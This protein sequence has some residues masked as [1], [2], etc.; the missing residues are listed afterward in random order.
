MGSVELS[1]SVA[2]LRLGQFCVDSVER[3]QQPHNEVS[4]NFPKREQDK[5]I[6]K[7]KEKRKKNDALPK[8]DKDQG[9]ENAQKVS[10]V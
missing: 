10:F 2:D 4:T 8:E 7:Q 9:A 3:E 1:V 6:V 5:K